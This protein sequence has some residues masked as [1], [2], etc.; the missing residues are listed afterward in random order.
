MQASINEWRLGSF[1]AD[2]LDTDKQQV[3]Y[4]KHLISLY[5]YEGAAESRLARFRERWFEA[6][7]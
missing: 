6:G 2:E 4:Q 1:K 5:Q 7:L 3:D